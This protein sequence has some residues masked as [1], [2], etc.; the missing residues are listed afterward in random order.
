VATAVPVKGGP[1]SE[2]APTG[3]NLL[4][5][6]GPG[7][8]LEGLLADRKERTATA[9]TLGAHDM[10]VPLV[11]FAGAAATGHGL[12]DLYLFAVLFDQMADIDDALV[13]GVRMILIMI[14]SRWV[15]W[16]R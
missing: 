12:Y 3:A 2:T 16:V 14:R 11:V 10:H 9:L 1:S 4:E 5:R 8:L 15:R 7:P 13:A 6:L